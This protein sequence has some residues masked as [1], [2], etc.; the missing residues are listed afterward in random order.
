MACAGHVE[1]LVQAHVHDASL[2]F[3]GRHVGARFT[4]NA[5]TREEDAVGSIGELEAYTVFDAKARWRVAEPITLHLGVN[6]LFDAIYATQRRNGSQ[7]GLFPGPTR[8]FYVAANA[9][10]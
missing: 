5:N 9:S 6:N 3:Q 10:F 8:T 7:K 4:D 1:R 2:T